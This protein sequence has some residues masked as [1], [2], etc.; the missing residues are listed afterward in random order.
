MAT[1][2]VWPD[3]LKPLPGSV[4]ACELLVQVVPNASRTA[5]AGL[6]DGALRVRLMAPPIEGRANA[7]LLQW[8][9]RSLELP[10]RAVVLQS[11]DTQRRKRIRLD[12]A[13]AVVAAWLQAQPGG[14]GR[15][16]GEG[17]AR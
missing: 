17:S 15:P 6:H 2:N 7:A 14:P 11:G 8:L 12:C 16:D 9:A 13:P 5:C 1:S 10:R 4:S 3:C